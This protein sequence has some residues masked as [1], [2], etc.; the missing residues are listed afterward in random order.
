VCRANNRANG[1]EE[2]PS[3]ECHDGCRV[4]AE[5][6]REFSA[7][8]TGKTVGQFLMNLGSADRH[9]P[10]GVEAQLDPISVNLQHDHFNI[11]PDEHSLAGF[12][13]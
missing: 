5:L 9:I 3:A 6:V 11:F 10:R 2:S 13:A 1:T 12:S 7:F 4:S 8:T